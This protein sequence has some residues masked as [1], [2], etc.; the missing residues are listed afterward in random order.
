MRNAIIA[1]SAALLAAAAQAPAQSQTTQVPSSAYSISGWRLECSSERTALSCQVLDQV[2]ARANS[3]VIAGVS[4]RE[5]ADGKTPVLIVQV[6]LGVAIDQ[7]VHVGFSGG[8]EQVLPF[9]S[10]YANGC[11]AR[12]PLGDTLLTAMRTA[13]QPLSLTYANLDSN[14]NKQSIRVTLPLDGFAVAYDKLK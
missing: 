14:L 5:A 1:L 4:V 8:A 6:P 9:V 12:A 10:C 7:P 2:F 3:A 11:F 13:K